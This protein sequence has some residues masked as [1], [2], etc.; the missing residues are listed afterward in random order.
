MK[1]S[2]Y[3]ITKR[4]AKCSNF[5]RVDVAYY[6][7]YKKLIGIGEVLTMDEAHGAM[8]SRELKHNWFTPYDY[9]PYLID[10][11]I[12]KPRFLIMAIVLLKS[13]PKKYWPIGIKSI[14]DVLVK[15]NYYEAFIGSW[16]NLKSRIQIPNSILI[17]TEDGIE[18]L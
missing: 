16:K 17:I 13:A 3:G 18:E 11:A 5:K 14:D 12:D 10:N 6:D 15:K 2:E 8:S 4:R 1:Y 7:L 9:I